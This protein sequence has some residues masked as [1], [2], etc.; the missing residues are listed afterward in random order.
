[1]PIYDYKCN[2]CGTTFEMK[3]SM[4]EDALTTCPPEF[5]T[6]P[7]KGVGKVHRVMSKNIGLVFKGT[8]FY[9]TDYA[10]KTGKPASAPAAETS[11]G[12]GACACDTNKTSVA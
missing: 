4:S 10:A 12:S 1:M 6:A 8:G 5:C 2:T 7:V 11:C 9:A 3:Q